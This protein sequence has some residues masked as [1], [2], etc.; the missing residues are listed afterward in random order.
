MATEKKKNKPCLIDGDVA[1][2]KAADSLAMFKLSNPL[3][4][5]VF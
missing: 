2:C 4:P 3:S 1:L 5:Y